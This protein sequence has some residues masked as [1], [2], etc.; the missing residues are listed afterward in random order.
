MNTIL[1]IAFIIGYTFIAI[2]NKIHIN[3]AATALF[4]GVICWTIYAI[5][6]TDIEHLILQLGEHTGSISQIL[7]FL[8]GAMTIVELIDSHDGFE[9]IT[10]QI[11]LRTKEDFFGLLVLLHSFYQQCWII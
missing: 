8:I 11:Q 1:I 7:F 9:V 5:F 2:E 4:T 10:K 3:K 6:S